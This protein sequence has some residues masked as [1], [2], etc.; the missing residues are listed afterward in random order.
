MFNTLDCQ[1]QRVVIMIHLS[2]GYNT[3]M[4]ACTLHLQEKKKK[5]TNQAPSQVALFNTDHI[6]CTHPRK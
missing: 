3:S 2:Q 4:C 1:V 6:C 5:E